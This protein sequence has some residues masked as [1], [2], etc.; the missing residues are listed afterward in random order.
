M[1]VVCGCTRMNRNG[2][3]DAGL[4]FP[5]EEKADTRAGRGDGQDLTIIVEAPDRTFVEKSIELIAFEQ[6]VRDALVKSQLPISGD[7]AV[8][9]V[10]ARPIGSI[11]E[12]KLLGNQQRAGGPLA[13]RRNLD[14][15]DIRKGLETGKSKIKH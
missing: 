8:P 3:A 15:P 14:R 13:N 11:A 6:G 4:P 7:A 12:I 5:G 9:A 1:K 10:V 2:N